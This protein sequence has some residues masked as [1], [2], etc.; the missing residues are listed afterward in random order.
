MDGL[1]SEDETKLAVDFLLED[2]KNERNLCD[3]AAA[4]EDRKQVA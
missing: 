1:I 2:L 4:F 3:D